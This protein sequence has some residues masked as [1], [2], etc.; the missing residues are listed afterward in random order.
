MPILIC[1]IKSFAFSL[2]K[3]SVDPKTRAYFLLWATGA[4]C[5]FAIY[6]T[7]PMTVVTPAVTWVCTVK[8]GPVLG[9]PK[10]SPGQFYL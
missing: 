9:L 6:R 8:P 1:A 7:R 3:P 2:V 5:R 10:S 4:V